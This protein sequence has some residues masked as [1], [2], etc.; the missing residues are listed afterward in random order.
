MAKT[1]TSEGVGIGW[2][3]ERATPQDYIF[4]DRSAD[5]ML[6]M[7]QIR[8]LKPRVLD[9]KLYG[10]RRDQHAEGSCVGHGTSAGANRITRQDGDT[11]DTVYS[12]RFLYNMAR[13]LEAGVVDA[14]RGV[15]LDPGQALKQ[16]NGAYVRDGVLAL[17]KFGACPE[18]AWKYRA[19]IREGDSAPGANDFK[20]VPTMS[21]IQA[22]HRF[23][24]QA[25]RCTTIEGVLSALIARYPVVYGTVC[26]TGMWTPT[27]D[28][29]G[30]FPMPGPRDRD[31]GGHCMCAQDADWEFPIPGA[32]IP[33]V[34]WSEN[35]WS[36]KWAG[37][38]PC[39]IAGFAA[40]PLEYVRRGWADDTWALIT[41]EG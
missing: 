36:D 29:T 33:G 22:A 30:V 7:D 11:Y 35:S 26:H 38:S 14:E 18:S 20:L 13:I 17:R 28:R 10:P 9:P 31:D 2:K 39:G 37:Q 19:H 32:S 3:P 5:K 41:E 8:G 12:P 40:L 15:I 21:R 16:D 6:T 1:R 4:E 24:V 23:R 34:L 25:Q 27:V